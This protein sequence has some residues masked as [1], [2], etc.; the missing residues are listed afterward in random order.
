[1]REGIGES[2]ED[3][4]LSIDDYREFERW[5]MKTKMK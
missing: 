1:M 3:R 4:R 5:E 2:V